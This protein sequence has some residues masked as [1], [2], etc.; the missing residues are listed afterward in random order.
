MSVFAL[1]AGEA[2]SVL[3][4]ISS[5]VTSKL[6]EGIFSLY[7]ALVKWHPRYLTQFV[8]L[9]DQKEGSAQG[10]Q[11]G[12]GLRELFLFSLEKGRLQ[13][14]LR[15]AFKCSQRVS[16]RSKSLPRGVW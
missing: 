11:D 7:L 10:P 15:A 2:N 5:K 4:W 13:Y 8:A 16:R 14:D 1:A 6:T 9:Q 12:K 3:G